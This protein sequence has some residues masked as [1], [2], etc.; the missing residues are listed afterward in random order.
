MSCDTGPQ[1][2][3][4]GNSVNYIEFPVI[5]DNSST[6][7]SRI[8]WQE[9]NQLPLNPF[10]STVRCKSAK[11]KQLFLGNI[12]TLKI[13][14][15]PEGR[16]ITY[17]AEDFNRHLKRKLLAKEYK[18][19]PASLIIAESIDFSGAL[20]FIEE[21]IYY[22]DSI[23]DP[24]DPEFLIKREDQKIDLKIDGQYLS[25]ILNLICEQIKCKFKVRVSD[26]K[27]IIISLL[28]NILASR[29]PFDIN[30]PQSLCDPENVLYENI[31]VKYDAPQ[32]SQVVDLGHR[33]ILN[34]PD[35]EANT[36]TTKYDVP[37]QAVQRYYGLQPNCDK[38][39]LAEVIARVITGCGVG[40]RTIELLNAIAIADLEF[41][42]IYKFAY[43]LPAE[44]TVSGF[45]ATA[46][47][48]L[49]KVTQTINGISAYSNVTY[50]LSVLHQGLDLTVTVKFN[51]AVFNVDTYTM[52]FGSGAFGSG[53]ADSVFVYEPLPVKVD[54]SSLVGQSGTI[55]VICD[56]PLQSGAGYGGPFDHTEFP[57][58]EAVFDGIVSCCLINTIAGD[59]AY[60]YGTDN[61][62]GG[63]ALSARIN[64]PL[65][66][67]VNSAGDYYIL[68]PFNATIR[69]VDHTTNIISP[70]MGVDDVFAITD[71]AFGSPALGQYLNYPAACA[72]DVSNNFYF[73]D[74]NRGYIAKIDT[75]GIITDLGYGAF[76]VSLGH[77]SGNNI[78][79]LAC[80]QNILYACDKG[81]DIIAKYESGTWSIV[82]GQYNVS[83]AT[84]NGG[85]ATAATLYDPVAIAVDSHGNIYLAD[86]S[87]TIRKI[88]I[89]SGIIDR[90]A[91]T[92]N[93]YDDVD[94]G[95]GTFTEPLFEGS[96]LSV[97]VNNVNIMS[98]CF[99]QSDNC[100]LLEYFSS[101]STGTN[102]VA[103]KIDTMGNVSI[104]IN[105]FKSQGYN[106]DNI[107]PYF[108]KIYYDDVAGII[109]DA[110]NHRI[111]FS[112]QS[113]NR[114]RAVS[115]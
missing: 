103:R 19:Q 101:S 64:Y 60:G 29:T 112:D 82:A 5:N 35:L 115:C 37:S 51:G 33:A 105:K 49:V 24:L 28:A 67:A 15:K 47:E 83:S 70:V 18:Q 50:V 113:N 34:M 68:N 12:T 3:V 13:E 45:I 110:A 41:I 22:T 72:V 88:D 44:V 36:T 38:V 20:P 65:K 90:W 40:P 27:L 54:L 1:I 107:G 8:T 52:D 75:T 42:F 14:Y 111:I 71:P 81:N 85:L 9:L 46:T 76:L 94:D 17:T 4:N 48:A 7:A 77:G 53:G 86:V 69:K 108:A 6:S 87:R 102:N 114:I 109:Y 23:A 100:Y 26:G 58:T 80:Y 97:T 74:Q 62:D 31:S 91:G 32:I 2:L 73:S 43:Y 63:D 66:V 92:G 95:F 11:G 57:I 106:G 99:D 21:P 96:K 84:G 78:Y 104:Y 98:F 61:G 39:I 89:T 55:E 79:D 59:G 16:L 93:R 30:L 56:I 25:D 10:F